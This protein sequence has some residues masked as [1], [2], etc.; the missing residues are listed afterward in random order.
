MLGKYDC[1]FWMFSCVENGFWFA[2][3]VIFWDFGVPG[4]RPLVFG[5]WALGS[6]HRTPLTFLVC[7]IFIKLCYRFI[8]R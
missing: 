1:I 6:G 7:V 4:G 3:D 5:R 2:F 8:N